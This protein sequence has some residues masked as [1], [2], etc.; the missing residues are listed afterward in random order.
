[1][2]FK[3]SLEARQLEFVAS[4]SVPFLAKFHFAAHSKSTAA[5]LL[6]KGFGA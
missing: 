3:N 4:D 5:P 6:R 1:M 2:H